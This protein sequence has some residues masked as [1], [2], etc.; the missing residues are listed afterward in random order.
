MQASDQRNPDEFAQ[1]FSDSANDIVDFM[2]SY[3]DDI[4]ELNERHM[5][6]VRGHLRSLP[7]DVTL[8]LR[9][10]RKPEPQERLD[11]CKEVARRVV[12]N[13]DSDDVD[14]ELEEKIVRWLLM[15]TFAVV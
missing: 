9:R 8:T 7:P 2:E 5:V 6:M 15:A 10:M 1:P 3:P 11:V 14:D 12:V 13:S 4:S